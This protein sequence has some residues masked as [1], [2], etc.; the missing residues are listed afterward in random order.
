M[1]TTVFDSNIYISAF[2]FGGIP[3]QLVVLALQGEFK[4]FISEEIVTEVLAVSAK[5]FK[6]NQQKIKRL[7]AFLRDIA[8]VV[9]PGMTVTTIKGWAADNRILECAVEAN[10]HYLVTGDKKHLLPMKQFKG[11]RIVSPQQFLRI[12]HRQK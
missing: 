7:D 6:Y 1:L 3:F 12:L 9:H 8:G 10:A 11:I 5:K 2:N 4:L